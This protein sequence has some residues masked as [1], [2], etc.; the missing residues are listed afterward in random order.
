MEL[1]II[2]IFMRRELPFQNAAAEITIITCNND[3]IYI[4]EIANKCRDIY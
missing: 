4:C 2:Y 3:T 1:L